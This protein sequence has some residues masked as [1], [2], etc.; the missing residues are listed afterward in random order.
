M[1]LQDLRFGIEIETV[2]QPRTVAQAIQMVVGGIIQTEPYGYNGKLTSS[3]TCKGV[4]GRWFTTA[5]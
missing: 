2:G 1:N 4:N 3:P 5:A